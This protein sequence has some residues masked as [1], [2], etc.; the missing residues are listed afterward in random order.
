MRRLAVLFLLCAFCLAQAQTV[1]TLLKFSGA[2]PGAQGTIGVTFALYAGQTGGAPLWLETQSVTCDANGRFTIYLGA[3]HAQG[4]P[5]AL[6]AAGEPRWLGIQPDGQPEQPRIILVSVPY[7][8]K[9]ADAET[10]GGRPAAAYLLAPQDAGGNYL[11]PAA[12]STAAYAIS[13]TTGYLAKFTDTSGSMGN[14]L[15]YESGGSLGVGTT[16]PSA[17]FQV[18]APSSRLFVQSTNFGSNAGQWFESVPEDGSAAK[19]GGVYFQGG[20]T[21][22]TTYI[23]FTADDISYQLAAN[24]SGNVGVGT[25]SPVARLHT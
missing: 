13:G 6:F 8:L 10:L 12:V 14:S 1:P 23:G 19:R 7:A 5:A 25:T 15:L 16:S 11:N 17:R 22:D 2:V 24:A 21:A 3:T 4:V 20:T 18:A 9:A